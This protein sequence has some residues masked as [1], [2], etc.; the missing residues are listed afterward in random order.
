M[1][2]TF[3]KL[4]SFFNTLEILSISFW[5]C[6]T[7][8]ALVIIV[9]SATPKPPDWGGIIAVGFGDNFNILAINL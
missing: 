2:E 7:L 4:E 1:I 5:Y 9:P 8:S 6:L 3:K